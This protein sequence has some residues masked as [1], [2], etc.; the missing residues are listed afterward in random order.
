MT[1]NNL[2]HTKDH[3]N[4][5]PA[6]WT[7]APTLMYHVVYRLRARLAETL[8]STG[9]QSYTRIFTAIQTDFA[10]VVE[11]LAAGSDVTAASCGGV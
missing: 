4:V 8:M 11:A 10:A 1:G 5:S 9:D 7:S 3:G 6:Q 2:I